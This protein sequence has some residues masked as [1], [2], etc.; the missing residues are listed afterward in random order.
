MAWAGLAG[1]IEL[2]TGQTD[3]WQLLIQK[4]RKFG[5]QFQ[6]ER[7]LRFATDRSDFGKNL[8]ITY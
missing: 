1:Y 3:A 8:D 7:Q 2:L 4:S 5:Q 6:T